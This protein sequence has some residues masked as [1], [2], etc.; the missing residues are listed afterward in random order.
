V[1]ADVAGDRIREEALHG[2][3]LRGDGDVLI[4]LLGLSDQCDVNLGSAALAK[5]EA[6][7]DKY[8]MDQTRGIAPEKACYGI[9]SGASGAM[10][11]T[12]ARV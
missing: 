12:S 9:P 11:G 6:S 3:R 10:S 8:T 1:P 4:D 2:S 5:I 7:A